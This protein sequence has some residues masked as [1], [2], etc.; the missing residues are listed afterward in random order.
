MEK[1]PGTPALR[2][3]DAHEIKQPLP[4]ASI[5]CLYYPVTVLSDSPGPQLS[6]NG[7]PERIIRFS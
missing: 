1:G 7:C 3:S 2:P 5:E 6:T 4:F